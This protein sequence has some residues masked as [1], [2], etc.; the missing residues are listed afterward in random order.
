MNKKRL[1]IIGAGGHGRVVSDIASKC[2]YTDICFLDDAGE[3]NPLVV[4]KVSNFKKYIDNAEFFVAIGNS[5]VREKLFCELLGC[6]AKI[7]ILIHPNAVVAENV[8]IGYGTAVMAGAVINPNTRIGNGAI[9]NTCSS[10]DHDCEVA[11]FC[12][13]SVGAHLCG[14]VRIDKHTWIGAG[15]T[16]INNISIC[17]GC[18]IGAGAAVVKDIKDDGVYVGVPAK[19]F[20]KL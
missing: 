8:E 1:M 6:G 18:M 4:D 11:D 10:V 14:T 20:K 7:A 5:R 3:S 19:F 17:S 16:V 15:A 13:V 12:H 2:G 9:I